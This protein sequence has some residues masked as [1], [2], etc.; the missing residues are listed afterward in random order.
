VGEVQNFKLLKVEQFPRELCQAGP[1]KIKFGTVGFC[2]KE[3]NQFVRDLVWPEVK[4]LWFED[5]RL[6]QRFVAYQD[7][8]GLHP[9]YKEGWER[10]HWIRTK[11]KE[12]E[13]PKVANGIW[14]PLNLVVFQMQQFEAAQ[15][16]D[17]L[18]DLLDRVV[19]Q[20]EFA[21]LTETREG[22]GQFA[23][24]VALEDQDA[25]IAQAVEVRQLFHGIVAQ[26][27]ILQIHQLVN[28]LR[29][30]SDPPATEVEMGHLQRSSEGVHNGCRPTGH[31]CS[32]AYSDPGAVGSGARLS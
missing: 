14:Q 29:K 24:P 27:E 28:S 9:V 3:S 12:L 6:D 20:I 2:L 7:E 26:M 11:V 17:I 19:S 23:Q 22:I 18:G 1:T 4:L 32:V 21:Q 8:A 15:P 10:L 30:A 25:Q 16:A 31:R 5:S 13:G